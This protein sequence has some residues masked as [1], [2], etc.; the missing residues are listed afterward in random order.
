MNSCT[1][2]RDTEDLAASLLA[3]SA[4]FVQLIDILQQKAIL[5]ADE[6]RSLYINSIR[7]LDR[8][9]QSNKEFGEIYDLAISIISHELSRYSK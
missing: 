9:R 8:D 1:N 6:E 5:T 7:D 3:H 2:A 4:C